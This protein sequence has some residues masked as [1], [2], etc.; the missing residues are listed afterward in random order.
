MDVLNAAG[1]PAAALSVRVVRQPCKDITYNNKT[2]ASFRAGVRFNSTTDTQVRDDM[3]AAV[4][5]PDTASPCTGGYNTTLYKNVAALF[6]KYSL[7]V[8]QNNGTRTNMFYNGTD[9][10]WVEYAGPCLPKPKPIIKAIVVDTPII[11]TSCDPAAVEALA[12]GVRATITSGLPPAESALV[13]VEVVDC[14]PTA[15]GRRLLAS[16]V[17]VTLSITTSPL[18][19]T[20]AQVDA[21]SRALYAAVTGKPS[22][23]LPAGASLDTVL[24]MLNTDLQGGSAADLLVKVQK[25]IV[26]AN[27]T[28]VFDAT[29]TN[30]TQVA[31]TQQAI[32]CPNK[33]EFT[34]ASFSTQ[35]LGQIPGF[36]CIG[37]CA[38]GGT[39]TASCSTAGTWTIPAT[40]SCPAEQQPEKECTGVPSTTPEGGAWPTG[41]CAGLAPCDA[42]CSG[43][44]TGSPFAVCD[45]V[46]GAWSAISGSCTPIRCLDSPLFGIAY[47]NWA[48]NCGTTV[49]STCTAT[50]VG[51]GQATIA[52]C[53]RVPGT[54]TANW[55]LT[56][57]GNCASGFP[58][59]ATCSNTNGAAS[60]QLAFV[61]GF[62]FAPKTSAAGSSIATLD[63]AAAKAIC[64]DA[65]YPADATCATSWT[66]GC[67]AGSTPNPAG[68]INGLVVG[69]TAAQSICCS[70]GAAEV[71]PSPTPCTVSSYLL[72][73]DCWTGRVLRHEKQRMRWHMHFHLR[74]TWCLIRN[75]HRRCLHVQ[76]H[77]LSANSLPVNSA[78]GLEA[79]GCGSFCSRNCADGLICN[80]TF[81][82]QCVP[83]CNSTISVGVGATCSPL[84]DS[85]G[86]TCPRQCTAGNI[87]NS[88]NVCE[89]VPTCSGTISVGL[90]SPCSPLSNSCGGTCPR[91]CTSG[92]F[93]NITNIC[94][95]QPTCTDDLAVTPG[96]FCGQQS[97]GCSGFCTKTCATTSD[98]LGSKC[99]LK[100]AVTVVNTITPYT[101]AMN[102]N[103][104]TNEWFISPESTTGR[105]SPYECGIVDLASQPIGSTYDPYF[106]NSLTNPGLASR[107]NPSAA[108][109]KALKMVIRS[110]VGFAP[111]TGDKCEAMIAFPGNN[112]EA[113]GLFNGMTFSDF[114]TTGGTI[115]WNWYKGVMAGGSNAPAPSLKLAV[116]DPTAWPWTF[117]Y[118]GRN[119][120]VYL[121][122][123]PYC[124]KPSIA[125]GENGCSVTLDVNTWSGNTVS[126]GQSAAWV[127]PS[128]SM[129]GTQ[130]SCNGGHYSLAWWMY[131]ATSAAKR[132]VTIGSLSSTNCEYQLKWDSASAPYTFG[133]NPSTTVAAG[134]MSRAVILSIHMQ[135]GSTS[136][137]IAS[138]VGWLRIKTGASAP[139]QYDYAWEFGG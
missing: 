138:F 63:A 114:L 71:S 139:V 132:T 10:Y 73:R 41:G 75:M 95:C 106:Q 52:T 86:G 1:W 35:C 43:D 50:C 30:A 118:S 122:M 57:P 136:A 8:S 77:L 103:L 97:D 126:E 68:L 5:D 91:Q 28:T 44:A 125:F 96:N 64:C 135:L 20:A 119:V 111:G 29:L 133:S 137:N 85:C 19:T 131:P 113:K 17:T 117:P 81:T 61:C 51:A 33:P 134:F 92:T 11:G 84:S 47:A 83:T 9:A 115:E 70:G 99:Q 101:S 55:N 129:G 107:T 105:P 67:P 15:T 72:R 69:S 21:A 82:C 16:N 104:T 93:C 46:T 42:T 6:A 62:G 121:N 130:S 124:Q 94:Q 80:S 76:P 36:D 60:G 18:L 34:G 108:V 90:G 54:T 2:Y 109:T 32:T 12:N 102:N 87:C 78:C 22:S 24:Q 128:W 58:A 25:A 123:E 48:T 89:C 39:V 7:K 88:A 27:L 3:W 13:F 98:C 31:G 23:S 110:N 74:D 65:V 4:A 66:A 45:T 26:A 40:A 38:K 79:N 120:F 59:N 49:G 112:G 14:K 100:M 53:A 127:G 116:A 56:T 37:S